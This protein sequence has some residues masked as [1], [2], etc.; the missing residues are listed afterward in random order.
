VETFGDAF[1]RKSRQRQLWI[2][3]IFVKIR[4]TDSD[5]TKWLGAAPGASEQRLQQG[6]EVVF[7]W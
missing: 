3:K 1:L 2:W 4:E 5:Q 7:E 6:I